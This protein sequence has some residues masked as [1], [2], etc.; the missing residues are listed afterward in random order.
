MRMD[1]GSRTRL[2]NGV[3]M[4]WLGYGTYK[5][6]PG[7]V[8][9]KAVT[10]ALE[11]G[12][13]H[14]DTATYYGNEVDVGNA[15]RKSDIV[16]DEI[17]V[18]T[19]LWNSDQGYD[20]ASRAFEDSI[21]RLDIEY[22]DLYLIHWPVP[23]KFCESWA[24]LEDVYRSGRVRAIGVSNFLMHHLE[25]LLSDCSV[26]P[27]I[28]QVEFH[29]HL[30]RL[31]LLEFCGSREI[32]M[33]AWSP[34][35]QGAITHDGRMTDIGLRYGKSASQ[36]TLRWN[37]Q[38]EVVTIPRTINRSHMQENADIFDFELTNAEMRTIDS[39]DRGENVGP[40]PDRVD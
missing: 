10:D 6:G 29:P 27:V 7:E 16:R 40:D 23:G 35:K 31:D 18:T 21:E 8:A 26:V 38:H 15:I 25:E 24:A 19:K 1:L 20:S 14:I 13:R 9:E 2:N 34:L 33:E 37:L 36:V 12:Y 30:A 17:F 3:E 22:L 11:V 39:M 5:V 4:P 32:Q 28:D